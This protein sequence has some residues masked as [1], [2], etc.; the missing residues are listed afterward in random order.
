MYAIIKTGGK[1]YRV[2]ENDV[3]A[4]D[5]LAVPAGDSIVVKEVL[6]VSGDNGVKIGSPY[7]VG[8]EVECKIMRQYKGRKI[9]SITYK[10]KK[11]EA[12]RYGHRQQLTSL[13]ISKISA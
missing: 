4:V 9:R 2:A 7:V 10:P 6:L 1:Q 5:K 12:K 11:S 13:Q 3:I 8:A